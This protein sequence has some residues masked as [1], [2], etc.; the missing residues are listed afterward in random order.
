MV[1]DPIRESR[2]LGRLV[3]ASGAGGLLAAVTALYLEP[4]FVM[5]VAN[6]LWTCF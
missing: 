1:L 6:Q 3:W 4:G 2:W 5:T